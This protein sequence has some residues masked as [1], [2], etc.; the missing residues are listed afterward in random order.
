MHLYQAHYIYPVSSSPLIDGIVAIEGEQIVAVGPAVAIMQQFPECP[1]SDLGAAMLFPQAVNAH[2]H[3]DQTAFAAF[4]QMSN[5][6]GGF[7]RWINELVATRRATPLTAMVEGAREGVRLVLESGTAAVGDFSNNLISVEPLVNSGLYGVVYY[8]LTGPNPRDAPRLL[9]QAQE[10]VKQWRSIYGEEC[11]RFGVAL[12]APYAVS[13]DLFRLVIDWVVQDQI[14]SSLHV[15]ESAAEVEFLL[16]G[17]GEM[18][19]Y[20]ST[21]YAFA[22]EWIPTPGCSPIQYLERL[23]VLSACPL[24]IHGIQVTHDDIQVL[25]AHEISMAH[26]ARSNALLGCGRMPI[27]WYQEAGVPLAMGT[28]GLSSSPSLSMWDEAKAALRLHRAAG[29]SLDPHVLLRLCTLDGA[30]ALGFEELLGSLEPGK[31]ARLAIGRRSSSTEAEQ[32]VS[33]PDEML[34]LLWD[35]EITVAALMTM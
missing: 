34:Q 29:I 19:D 8:L 18:L 28:D 9:R 15:A 1:V 5:I 31:V 20:L 3:L 4:G 23:G 33:T 12:Q 22:P 13:P 6:Q 25:A 30:R 14:P 7:V 10:Q 32:L 35:G 2:T 17:S 16:H 21:R 27:E 24:L 11:I 26:C